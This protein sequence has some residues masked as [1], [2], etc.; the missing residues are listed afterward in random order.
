METARFVA[1][2]NTMRV[3]T[4]PWKIPGKDIVIP[5]G[6]QTAKKTYDRSL[7]LNEVDGL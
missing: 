7:I 1:F 5:K 2:P 3:C 4:K 6:T